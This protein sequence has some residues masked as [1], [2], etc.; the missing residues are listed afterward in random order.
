MK[1]LNSFSPIAASLPKK[2]IIVLGVC[3]KKKKVESKPMK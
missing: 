3:A 2:N 1:H